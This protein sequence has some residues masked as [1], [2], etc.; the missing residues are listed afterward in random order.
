MEPSSGDNSSNEGRI[1]FVKKNKNTGE[2]L[3]EFYVKYRRLGKKER[4]NP[5]QKTF[6][7]LLQ[8]LTMLREELSTLREENAA[9]REENA[10]LKE[11][12]DELKA[13]VAN[14]QNGIPN[15]ELDFSAPEPATDTPTPKPEPAPKPEQQ[16]APEL[17]PENEDL[18]NILLGE[19]T[20]PTPKPELAPEPEQ[21]PAPELAPEDEDLTEG[22]PEGLHHHI[23]APDI[24]VEGGNKT[25]EE[26]HP[27]PRKR[28]RMVR[29]IM[30]RQLDSLTQ[31]H[32]SLEEYK[33]SSQ[34]L[35]EKAIA[36]KQE[37]EAFLADG[38]DTPE[39]KENIEYYAREIEKLERRIKGLNETISMVSNR[40]IALSKRLYGEQPEIDNNT[41]DSEP[42]E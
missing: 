12:I 13:T 20:E 28:G 30:E 19:Q 4:N 9:L 38:E 22:L 5:E 31:Q 3:D 2:K 34:E 42:E 11:G 18:F 8:E 36:E 1:K 21:Q 10:T 41:P 29:F 15:P 25:P 14:L 27:K 17:A 7:G 33:K 6:E 40:G 24:I 23:Y 16:P 32:K 37:W 26:N 35:L 39:V